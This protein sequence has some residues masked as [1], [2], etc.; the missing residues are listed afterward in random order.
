MTARS[1]RLFT[2]WLLTQFKPCRRAGKFIVKP[3][4]SPFPNR[5]SRHLSRGHYIRIVI[6]DTGSGISSEDIDKVFDPYFTTKEQGSG[7]GLSAS[8]SIIKNHEGNIQVESH[9]GKG[10]TFSIFLPASQGCRSPVVDEPLDLFSGTG[11][12]LVMDDEPLVQRC[13]G[14]HV[15]RTRIQRD[16]NSRW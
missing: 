3:Q 1:S 9:P 16:S 12:I 2:I 11:S 4:T 14:S 7:L 13:T 6:R 5:M 10:A 15:D 8:Y